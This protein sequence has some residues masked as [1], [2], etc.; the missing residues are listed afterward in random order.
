MSELIIEFGK[1]HKGKDVQEL[2]KTETL[3]CKWLLN[4]PWLETKYPKIYTYLTENLEKGDL[5]PFGKYK[6]KNIEYIRE[7]DPKYIEWL[8]K[9]EWVKENLKDIYESLY[10]P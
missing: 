7:K 8:K 2:I 3:Y 10:L 5:I 6:G 1:A 9:N 4:Q